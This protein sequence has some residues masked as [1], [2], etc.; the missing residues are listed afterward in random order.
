MEIIIGTS[1]PVRITTKLLSY[2]RKQECNEFALVRRLGPSFC[3]LIR[4]PLPGFY[5]FQVYALPAGVA[6]PNFIGVFNYIIHCPK[7]HEVRYEFVIR[8]MPQVPMV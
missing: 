2:E 7:K 5:K 3:Y 4:P 1:D 6:G 8:C